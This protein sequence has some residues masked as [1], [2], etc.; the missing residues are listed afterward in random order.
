MSCSDEI[1]RLRL[2]QLVENLSC[3]RGV[4]PLNCFSLGSASYLSVVGLL[5]TYFFVLFQMSIAEGQTA[6]SGQ[7]AALR[8][9]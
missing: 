1:L 8:G 3:S 9:S 5:L 7:D 6:C 4:C 2:D